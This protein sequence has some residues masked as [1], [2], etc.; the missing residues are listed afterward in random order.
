[1]VSSVWAQVQFDPGLGEVAVV[2]TLLG[3]PWMFS[4]CHGRK[5][6]VLQEFSNIDSEFFGEPFECLDS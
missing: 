3:G 2:L 5:L 1:M 6:W 4:D